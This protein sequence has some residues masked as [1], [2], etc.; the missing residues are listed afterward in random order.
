[1]GHQSAGGSPPTVRGERRGKD[2]QTRGRAGCAGCIFQS[3]SARSR[4][5]QGEVFFIAQA[6]CP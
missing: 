6:R 3:P 4:K 2:L 5:R 1:M